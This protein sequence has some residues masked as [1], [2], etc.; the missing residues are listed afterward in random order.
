MCGQRQHCASWLRR[1]C[2]PRDLSFQRTDIRLDPSRKQPRGCVEDLPHP[3]ASGNIKRHHEMF[4]L[5]EYAANPAT[6]QST[7]AV[8]DK[9]THTVSPGLLN[10]QGEIQRRDGL[11]GNRIGRIF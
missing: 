5:A 3:G 7:R 9:H 8:F 11:S 10:G 6:A 1:W 2:C 4:T